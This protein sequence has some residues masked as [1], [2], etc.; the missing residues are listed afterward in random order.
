[1]AFGLRRALPASLS[2]DGTARVPRM[3]SGRKAKR[4]GRRPRCDAGPSFSP[5]DANAGR[6]A[7]FHTGGVMKVYLIGAGP[8]D[9]G[10]LTLKGKKIP[11]VRM[12]SSTTFWPTMP[13]SPTPS[14]MPKS[15]M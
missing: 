7:R 1:M 5:F 2:C 10:L 13:S 8:G 15:S 12:W 14:P 9:P 4:G 3:T 11:N 6:D